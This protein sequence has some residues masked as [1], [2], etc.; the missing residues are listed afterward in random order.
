MSW[1]LCFCCASGPG[2]AEQPCPDGS[3]WNPAAFRALEGRG[4]S[5][6]VFTQAQSHGRHWLNAAWFEFSFLFFACGFG[7]LKYPYH[8]K[9]R[10]LF[11]S[12]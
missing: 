12:S 5:L 4:G 1:P 3:L 11:L 7:F 6:G 9:G 8:S 2:G 10:F